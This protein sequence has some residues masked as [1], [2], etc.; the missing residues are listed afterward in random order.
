MYTRRNATQ[1]LHIVQ[2]AAP[3]PG[4]AVG[5]AIAHAGETTCC[6]RQRALCQSG[7]R[8]LRCQ[9]CSSR[10]TR[11]NSHLARSCAPAER[12]RDRTSEGNAMSCIGCGLLVR[13][14][15]E[16]RTGNGR[17]LPKPAPRQVSL[18]MDASAAAAERLRHLQAHLAPDVAPANGVMRQHTA[19]TPSLWGNVSMVRRPCLRV[20]ALG[21]RAVRSLL[22]RYVA[23][24]A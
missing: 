6:V 18:M 10:V 24:V 7:P 23:C 19:G 3:G 14:R 5:R 20:A 15:S 2:C 8:K 1:L 13:S 12:A 4:C 9:D 17:F 22:W 11:F 16:Q 21:A